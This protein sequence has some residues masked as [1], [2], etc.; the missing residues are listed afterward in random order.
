MKIVI[1]IPEEYYHF[2]KRCAVNRTTNPEQRIIASGTP[3][4]TGEIISYADGKYECSSC[5]KELDEALIKY[6]YCPMCGTL[7]TTVTPF[8]IY[9]EAE[10][11]NSI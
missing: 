3:L 8:E 9:K 2:C 1:D 10:N 11:E 7:L 6:P 4:P 5:H